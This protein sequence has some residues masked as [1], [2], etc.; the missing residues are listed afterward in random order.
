LRQPRIGILVHFA[1]SSCV[2]DEACL[3]LVA[4]VNVQIHDSVVVI[5]KLTHS[6]LFS[7]LAESL[8]SQIP[9]ESHRSNSTSHLES[10]D[11]GDFITTLLPSA[12][13]IFKFA[14]NLLAAFPASFLVQ[15]TE[16]SHFDVVELDLRD[17]STLSFDIERPHVASRMGNSSFD[18]R[19]G[20]VISNQKNWLSE[21]LVTLLGISGAC[22]V[23][24]NAGESEATKLRNDDSLSVGHLLGNVGPKSSPDCADGLVI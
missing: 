7:C 14:E 24:S 15:I 3:T 22:K 13:I 18:F 8:S 21:L 6:K 12:S 2:V 20:E 23:D 11:Q 9:V 17:N 1:G 4:L 5:K 19:I 16:K 10:S